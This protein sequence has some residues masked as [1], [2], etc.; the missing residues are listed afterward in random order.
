MDF[1]LCFIRAR[2]LFYI[3]YLHLLTI[4]KSRLKVNLKNIQSVLARAKSYMAVC[5]FSFVLAF[6]G[7]TY[8]TAVNSPNQLK[9]HWFLALIVNVA[10]WI[11]A[12]HTSARAHVILCV[13]FYGYVIISIHSSFSCQMRESTHTA[14]VFTMVVLWA[15]SVIIVTD[16]ARCNWTIF[17]WLFAEQHRWDVVWPPFISLRY[18]RNVFIRKERNEQEYNKRNHF[19]K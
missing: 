16:I 9:S 18:C 13:G 15:T 5:S 14:V 6:Y 10:S 8:C 11:L 4:L 7:V 19:R 12:G 3:Q 17:P 1:L 2:W